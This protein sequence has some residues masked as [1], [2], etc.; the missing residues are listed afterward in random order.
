L[1]NDI[2]LVSNIAR[3]VRY[4]HV[5]W[6]DRDN[7]DNPDNPAWKEPIPVGSPILFLADRIEVSIKRNEEILGQ[8]KRIIKRIEE[9]SGRMFD[10]KLVE[11]FKSISR[12]ECFWL[13]LV[14]PLSIRF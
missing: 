12:Q 4:H 10:P 11:I 8:V 14:S 9:E 3:L 7:P 13:D 1:L 5:R 6:E 2:P